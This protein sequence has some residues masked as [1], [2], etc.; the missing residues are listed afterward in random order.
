VSQDN[1]FMV[2]ADEQEFLST[3]LAE[4]R[5]GWLVGRFHPSRTPTPVRVAPPFGAGQKLVL[6]NE[7]VL[8]PTLLSADGDGDY[9]GRY[10]P[11]MFRDPHIDLDRCYFLYGI[12]H[13]G[14]IFAKIGWCPTTSENA[15]LQRWYSALAGWI[16]RRSAKAEQAYWLGPHALEWLRRGGRVNPDL[17]SQVLGP[18]G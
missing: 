15:A 10:C 17:G 14:R 2:A 5:T 16:K 18:A 9:I 13:P 11:D 6:V 4:P 7:E 1:F 3:V 12:L 8:P